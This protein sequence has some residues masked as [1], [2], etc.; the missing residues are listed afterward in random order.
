MKW[1]IVSFLFKSHNMKA[2]AERLDRDGFGSAA[3]F[4]NGI[5]V[6]ISVHALSKYAPYKNWVFSEAMVLRDANP[7]YKQMVEYYEI[8]RHGEGKRPATELE[9]IAELKVKDEERQNLGLV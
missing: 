7:P 8:T 1:P 3:V 6:R 2:H 9:K 5:P 4:Y